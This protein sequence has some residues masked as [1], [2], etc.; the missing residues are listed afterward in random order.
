MRH[1]R[2]LRYAGF[3]EPTGDDDIAFYEAKLRHELDGAGLYEALAAAERRPFRRDLFARASHAKRAHAEAR[4]QWLISHGATL[5]AHRDGFRARILAALAAL[6]GS[7]FVLPAVVAAELADESRHEK[8]DAAAALGAEEIDA[9]AAVAAVAESGRQAATGRRGASGNDLRAAV[10]GAN[11]GL[12]SNFCLM[13]GVAGAGT[14]QHTML[15]TGLAGLVAGACSMALGEWLSVSNAR[16]LA[17]ELVSKQR[18]ELEQAPESGRQKLATIYEAKGLTHFDA[19]RV[20]AQIMQNSPAALD[21]LTREG[22]GV[23]PD[24]LGGN[25]WTAAGLSFAL[26]AI[27]AIVPVLPLSLLSGKVAIVVSV[28]ASAAA[29][30]LLGLL[31]SLFNGRSVSFSAF[32]QV[33]I[34]CAAAAVTYGAGAALGVSPT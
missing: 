32:R 15:L 10:L 13:M 5:G 19:Q 9:A 27:G 14:S 1:H 16:E 12:A 34:G 6:F 2:H 21:T 22:L 18:D 26:F 23:D 4:R 25:P 8:Q 30:A 31:T 3:A 28:A 33:L 20:A 11:D 17:T 29:L 7:R 24:E